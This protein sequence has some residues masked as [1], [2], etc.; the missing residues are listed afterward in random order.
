M[1][2]RSS[3]RIPVHIHATF[4]LSGKSYKG[5]IEN[6]SEDGAGSSIV[7]SFEIRTDFALTNM[8]VELSFRDPAGVTIQLRTELIWFTKS[9]ENNT[10]LNLGLRAV[11]PPPLY[12]EFI[13]VLYQDALGRKTK[14]QL[15]AELM[16]SRK[17]NAE[18]EKLVNG[19]TPPDISVRKN[20]ED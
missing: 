7:S 2:K 9:G 3:E 17:R 12:R 13:Q 8:F 6:V 15:I 14:K 4:V 1:K 11:D 10:V 20:E 18:L 19:L 16:E 5:L